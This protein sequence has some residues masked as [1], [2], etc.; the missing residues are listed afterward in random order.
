M[1][2]N[3]EPLPEVNFLNDNILSLPRQHRLRVIKS[4][5]GVTNDYIA[6][7]SGTVDEHAV[8]SA[9]KYP[10]AV[11]EVERTLVRLAGERFGSELGDD[12][13]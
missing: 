9:I 8:G 11:D 12:S 13:D 1:N 6:R 7:A 10:D 5:L 2:S 3:A 4:L